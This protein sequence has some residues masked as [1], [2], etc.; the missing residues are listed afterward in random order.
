MLAIVADLR[1]DIA[2]FLKIGQFREA[3]R[4]GGLRFYTSNSI[5]HVVVSAGEFSRDNV[6]RSLSVLTNDFNPTL[7]VSA[8]LASAAKRN[9]A[10]GGIVVCDRIMAVGGPAYIWGKEDRLEIE[11]DSAVIDA[12]HRQI[13][14][15]DVRYEVGSCL[16]LPQ[17][18]SKSHMKEWLGKTF[19]VSALD[20]EGYWVA[21]AFR[22]E[23]LPCLFVKA[24]SDT[25]DQTAS[26]MY[27]ETLKYSPA[28]RM[29]RSF[30]Y[31]TANP[32]RVFEVAKFSAQ[33]KQARNSLSRFLY[34][35]SRTEF[36]I[37]RN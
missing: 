32:S 3:S 25:M 16:S 7:V 15:G 34:R 29:L 37:S 4:E 21:D 10:T 2:G 12:V 17:F 22:R 24:M 5:P 26:P 11:T 23:R 30:G 18:I 36:D 6:A 28:R 14:V 19:D 31:I 8:G 13:S 20:T 9:L 27:V 33:V 35:L 1:R